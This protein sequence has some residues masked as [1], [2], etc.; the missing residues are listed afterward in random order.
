[1]ERKRKS[2]AMKI[3]PDNFKLGDYRSRC[4]EIF[5]AV[6][7]LAR[8]FRLPGSLTN[9]FNR[10]INYAKHEVSRTPDA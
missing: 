2:K 1:M 3:A 8:C 9:R 10:F 7:I 4:G 6:D 5:F